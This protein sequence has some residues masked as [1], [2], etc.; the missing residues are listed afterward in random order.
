MRSVTAIRVAVL[1]SALLLLSGC[2]SGV[3]T[4]SVEPTPTPVLAGAGKQI[5]AE[6]KV[7]PIQ[8][9][10]LVFQTTGTVAEILAQEGERI[11]KDAPLARLEARDQEL[12]VE[13][14]R[15]DLTRAHAN[16]E[17]LV[18]GATPEEIAATEA[19]LAQAE[20]TLRQNAGSVTKQDVAAA[21]S[22][23]DSARAALARLEA[24]PKRTEVEQI[25]AA[26]DQ[27]QANLQT[28]R[29]SL[30]AAK[31][32][33]ELAMRQAADALT[34]A[35]ARYAT[36]KQ[37]WEYVQETGADPTNPKTIDPASGESKKNKLNDVQKRQYYETFIQAEAAMHSAEKQLTVV[38]VAY[39]QAHQAEI[40]GIQNAEAQVRQAQATFDQLREGA[41]N[42][43]IAAARAEVAQAQANLDKLTGEQRAGQL[44]EARA[45]VQNAQARLNQL[46]AGPRKTD[47]AMAQAQVTAAELALKQTELVLARTTLRA[48]FAGTIAAINVD[49]GE[50][51]SEQKPALV[52]ADVSAW[53]I[54]TSDLTELD[55]VDIHEGDAVTI[56]F[57]AL[58]GVELM[59]TV[60]RIKPLGETYRGDMTYTV[61][62]I[63]KQY[64]AHL[65]WNMT[66]T[67]AVSK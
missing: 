65:R 8:S 64:D 24:G 1:A 22:Q 16:Y 66:A 38:Q 46:T 67:I 48:P 25:G 18:E 12:R 6:A 23:L 10:E 53:Q 17:Q 32:S 33:A 41:D 40:S 29:D 20:A 63:P 58:P 11:E 47:L 28:Q 30:S 19:S 51:A 62:V 35:Q 15:V 50:Q 39:D 27:A 37:N 49:V 52:L 5:I 31:T 44:E 54:E 57:D 55:V 3:A 21:R 9:A 56:S 7:V 34:Q 2:G 36:A 42:D 26:R 45:G 4:G 14:A 61:V 13:Q 43:Q 59:G 60:D